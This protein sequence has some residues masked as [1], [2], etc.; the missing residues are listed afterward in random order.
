MIKSS[1]NTEL[2]CYSI[3]E[4]SAE[5][6]QILTV[7]CGGFLGA[8]CRYLLSQWTS[9]LHKGPLPLA[10]FLVNVVGCF[11]IGFLTVFLSGFFPDRKNLSLFLTT[12][13]LGGFTTF[14]TFGLETV[15]LMQNGN[16]LLAL[17]NMVASLAFGLLGVCCGKLV[18]GLL[19]SHING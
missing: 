10:T 4:G 14:S 3:E 9:F 13:L 15:S 19:T 8:V 7:G 11:L 18:G 16:W 12:G 6:K 2:F 5:M 17:A 1:V